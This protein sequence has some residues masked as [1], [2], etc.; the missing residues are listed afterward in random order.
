M[1]RRLS[2]RELVAA[3]DDHRVRA[4]TD[5]ETVRG[6]HAGL[7]QAGEEIAELHTRSARLAAERD[8]AL[9]RARSAETVA[10]GLLEGQHAQR[11]EHVA[12]LVLLA[13][14]L[15]LQQA[16]QT[17]SLLALAELFTS[18]PALP[19]AARTP[20]EL[21]PSGEHAAIGSGVLLQLDDWIS[22]PLPAGTNGTGS[23]Q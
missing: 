22:G 5:A 8:A 11:A 3:L 13:L 6:L 20:P 2:R 19:A 7:W 4:E 23:G 10:R 1:S 9:D 18:Q 17:A 21:L 12:A 15:R 16:E 14:M